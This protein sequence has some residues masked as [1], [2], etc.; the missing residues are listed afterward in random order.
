ME[1]AIWS[2]RREIITKLIIR[3]LAD[4]PDRL[5]PVYGCLENAPEF[6]IICPKMYLI[7]LS[8]CAKINTEMFSEILLIGEHGSCIMP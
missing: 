1:K 8:E 3:F 2:P 5:S 7:Y 4:L 6:I